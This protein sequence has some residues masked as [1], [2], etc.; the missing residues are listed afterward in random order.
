MFD[1]NLNMEAQVTN[2][3]KSANFH[4]RNI[5]AIRS[6]LTDS[7]A[8]Q[9]VHSFI[10]SR[11]DYC[12]SLLIGLP[13]TQIKRLQRIQNNAA[14]IVAR[15]KKFDHVSQ[16]LSELHWLPVKKRIQFKMLLLTY[17]CLHGMAPQYLTELITPYEPSR[18]LRSS[19]K[20]LLTV[21]T[22]RLKTYGDKSFSVAA[23]KAWNKLP[24][25]IRSQTTLEHF[26]KNL[27]THLFGS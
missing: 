24:F 20:S 21:P 9:L 6:T 16:I 3:C 17:R 25:D 12:N 11:L 4:L 15:I 5:G 22:S 14:R 8:E 1:K 2:I 18:Q 7:S 10:T 26:K 27:K 19:D 23:P 13:D